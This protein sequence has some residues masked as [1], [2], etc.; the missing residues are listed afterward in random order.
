MNVALSPPSRVPIWDRSPEEIVHWSNT[1]SRIVSIR[2]VLDLPR[3]HGVVEEWTSFQKELSDEVSEFEALAKLER[4]ISTFPSELKKVYLTDFNQIFG[5]FSLRI[6]RLVKDIFSAQNL[7][8]G[9]SLL[10][11]DGVLLLRHI[12]GGIE[13]YS[14]WIEKSVIKWTTPLECASCDILRI[15][16]ESVDEFHVHHTSIL[17]F[18]H[19][20]FINKDSIASFS[21]NDSE[22][23]QKN[24]NSIRSQFTSKETSSRSIM[25]SERVNGNNLADFIISHWND[26]SEMQKKAIFHGIGKLALVDFIM[27]NGDRFTMF[28]ID[29]IRFDRYFESNIG[30]F[31]I[32]I[33]NEDEEGKPILYPID[34]A[35]QIDNLENGRDYNEYNQAFQN[36]INQTEWK[37][38]LSDAIIESLHS[39]FKMN[40]FYFEGKDKNR[41]DTEEKL[42]IFVRDLHDVKTQECVILGLSE[43]SDFLTTKFNDESFHSS[44]QNI[45]DKYNSIDDNKHSLTQ[46]NH[47]VK[48]RINLFLNRGLT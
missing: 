46:L 15:F 1:L 21:E 20:I 26:L 38:S 4:R 17:N 34:N 42:N 28:D 44:L 16:L 33:P 13:N 24:L 35:I 43:M 10:G 37:T 31:M 6:N 12:R 23:I 32:H 22:I 29:F 8:I 14:E 19:K 30:N 39:S 45:Q 25:I 41:A 2:N 36:L 18:D 48:A 47:A 7:S 5:C 40:S 11:N 3:T 9:E 27:G